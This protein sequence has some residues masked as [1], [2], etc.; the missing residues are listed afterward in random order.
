MSSDVFNSIVWH[1][2]WKRDCLAIL[3]CLQKLHWA[4]KLACTHEVLGDFD[5]ERAV[6]KMVVGREVFALFG[7]A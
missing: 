7:C 5:H 1:P 2:R 4:L 6:R 3:V